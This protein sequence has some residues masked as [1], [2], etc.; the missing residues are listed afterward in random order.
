MKKLQKVSFLIFFGIFLPAFLFAQ[1]VENNNDEIFPPFAEREEPPF[2]DDDESSPFEEQNGFQD[3]DKSEIENL[4][5]DSEPDSA[6]SINP[7]LQRNFNI[8]VGSWDWNLDPQTSSYSTEAQIL[9]GLYEGLFSYHPSTL[10]PV[11]AIAESYKISRDKKRWTFKIRENLKFSNGEEINAFTVRSN[12]I[13]LLQNKGA[14]Y[15]SLLDCIRNAED[16][17]NGKAPEDDLGIKARDNTTLVVTLK[18]PT[19]H[20]A[21]ILCHHAFSISRTST[22]ETA[23]SGAFK[24]GSQE[25]KKLVL[26]KNENYWDAENVHLPSITITASDDIAENSY[27]F[28]TGDYNW[29]SS[30]FDASKLINKNSIRLTAI[31]G[32]EYLFFGCK[33]KPWNLPEFRSA[34]MNAVPWEALRKLSL[35]PATTFIYPLAGYPKVEGYSETSIEDAEEMLAEARKNNGYSADEKIPLIFAVPANS[36][37][38]KKIAALLEEAFKPLNVELKVQTTPE[39]RY[40]DSIS[41]WN[42]DLFSYSWIGDF[43][44]PIAFLELFRG[45]STLNPTHYNNEKFNKLLEDSAL[46]SDGTEHYKLLAQAEQLLLDEGMVIPISHSLSFHA[47][48]LQ[49]IGG[50]YVN[51]LDIHPFKY[52]Y[53]KEDKS[54]LPDNVI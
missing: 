8:A 5:N 39:D 37:R 17:R 22:G 48:N 24:I 7:D 42:A 10:E 25:E 45:G 53:F 6:K 50:W 2:F 20:F 31:F 3:E 28:N 19:A 52:L 18:S 41:G 21:R 11:P 51:A 30:M 36:E 14:P 54:E 4:E 27:K 43:A 1:S 35:M 15:A 26:L 47:I 44:D 38:Q 13:S 40:V 9:S 49:E 16:F 33:N 34:L 23:F 32:T 46:A 12:W 29:V